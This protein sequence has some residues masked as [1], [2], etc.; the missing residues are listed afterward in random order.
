MSASDK[1]ARPVQ[2]P[3]PSRRR[4]LR[5]STALTGGL[6]I[7]FYLP[8]ANRAALAQGQVALPK[9]AALPA[10]AAV[11]AKPVY[12]PNAFIRI[13]PDD[14]VTVVVSKLEFGQ[15]VLTSLPMLIAEEL[16]CDWTQ[17]KSEHA[18]VAA[19][20]NHPGF[21]IQ[22]TGGSQS[23]ASS[24]DQLRLVGAQART[25]LVQAAANEWKVP[26]SECR[27]E[28]GKV[29]H[30]SGK[31]LAYGQ[32]ADA[33]NRLPLPEGVR[34]KDARD[35]RLIG[36]S[37]KRLDARAKTNGTAKFGIDVKFPGMLTAVVAR[38]PVFGAKVKSFDIA[39]AQGIAGVRYVAEIPSGVAVI[40]SSFWAAKS[41]R[42]KL[43][44]VWD[45]AA[46]TKI[47]SDTLRAQYLELAKTPGTPG[48]Q[49]GDPNAIKTAAKT[50]VA[51]YDVPYLAH[52]PMEPLNCT[53]ELTADA[54]K[55]WAGTQF[56]TV[57]RNAAAKAAGLKPEQ[58]QITTMLAGG[59]FGR[60]AV[61][62]SDWVVEAVYVARVVGRATEA[63]KTPPAVRVVWTRE[64][65]IKGGYYR[66][67]YVHRVE[68][69]IDKD[70]RAVAWNQVIVG[71]SILTGTPFEGFMVRNGIDA[72]SVE[73]AMEGY[74]IP[75]V[76]ISLHSPKTGIPVLW[77][78]SVGNTHTAFVKETMLDELAAAAG[79]D[80]L[81]YRK[82]LLAAG[83]RELG[84]L[85]LAADKAGW[86]K[87][88]PAGRARGIAVHESFGSVCAQV[89]EV[90]LDSGKIRV[91]KVVA[92]IDCGMAVNPAGVV[93]QV[94]SAIVFG[95]SAA[96]AGAI[97]FKDGKVE[98]SNFHD[99]APLRIGDTP[100]MEV[101]IVASSAPPSG[102]GEPGTPP[103]APAVAN[104]L[105]TLTGK[106]L[107]SM[108]FKVS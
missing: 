36:K 43:K 67:A 66:P 6:V 61:P 96:L 92:A 40:A 3:Q 81:D 82:T 70:G 86:G 18:P 97:T 32:V 64:D 80:P 41:A 99:Y 104:A 23:V 4:F 25:M 5:T 52:A 84:A 59:G 106:R 76:N 89:A 71:Q 79:K 73:G 48:K 9:P 108:P 105:F 101:H 78:R 11:P 102:V 63:G 72:T 90:S 28:T 85:T 30:T 37:T 2:A 10:A 33:A 100:Q 94:E 24:W 75:N 7:G 34:L 42:E 26:V 58:V 47:S 56:Q 103:I 77:W 14:S 68:A 12:P 27:A 62:D 39:E 22:M 16:E 69:G 49:T 31:K 57:D 54:C 20:Y 35:F 95:L 53:V 87:P 44:I 88:L 60:R 8:G 55:I 17:V 19:V 65:D 15:G 91:H 93:A 46:G 21:G 107:R 38:P 1:T 45:D 29:V 74:A 50:I 83:S 13:A 51:E 98:Q